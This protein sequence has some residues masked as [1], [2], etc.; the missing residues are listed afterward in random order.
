MSNILRLLMRSIRGLNLS[1]SKPVLLAVAA[2]MTMGLITAGCSAPGA[3]ADI[4]GL[5]AAPMADMPVA[6][7]SAGGRIAQAYRLAVT[8]EPLL[9]DIPC[10]CGCKSMGHRS[11]YDCYIAGM[12]EDGRRRFDMHAID[13]AVCVN[14]T[15]DALRLCSQGKSVPEIKTFIDGQYGK[16]GPSTG[17]TARVLAVF[18]TGMGKP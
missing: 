11:N 5:E 2:A 10:Y 16:I 13:C 12:G 7:R 4:H 3:A 8:H 17:S 1:K 9:R 18:N 6:V 14:I 15:H